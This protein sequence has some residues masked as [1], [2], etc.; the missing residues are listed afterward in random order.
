MIFYINIESIVQYSKFIFKNTIMNFLNLDS[1]LIPP[2]S[3]LNSHIVCM[4]VCF[5]KCVGNVSPKSIHVTLLQKSPRQ[6][7][8]SR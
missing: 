4:R 2:T 5:C 1:I 6:N 3:L 8:S 7:M